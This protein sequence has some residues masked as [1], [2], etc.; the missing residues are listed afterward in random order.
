MDTPTA[1]GKKF[2]TG[3]GKRSLF[4]IHHC[5]NFLLPTMKDSERDLQE[6]FKGLVPYRACL[7]LHFP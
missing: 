1:Q 7:N 6:E 3:E 5:Q 4:I 2:M